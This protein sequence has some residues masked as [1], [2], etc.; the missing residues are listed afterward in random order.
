MS[1]DD[2]FSYLLSLDRI[3]KRSFGERSKGMKI[4]LYRVKEDSLHVHSNDDV[5]SRLGWYHHSWIIDIGFAQQ[6]LTHNRQWMSSSLLPIHSIEALINSDDALSVLTQLYRE[7][8]KEDWSKLLVHGEPVSLPERD[9]ALLS[10]LTNPIKLM[11]AVGLTNHDVFSPTFIISP[12]S[13]VSHVKKAFPGIAFMLGS[14]ANPFIGCCLIS[15]WLKEDQWI[16]SLGPHL[17]ISN[18]WAFLEDQWLIVRYN[19]DILV[20]KKIHLDQLFSTIMDHP[21]WKDSF[22]FGDMISIVFDSMAISVRPGDWVDVQM[23]YLGQLQNRVDK[24]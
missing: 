18:Q 15:C 6:W 19:G 11:G 17:Y 8:L 12:H 21:V 20:K 4:V 2:I 3:N 5:G 16:S 22:S 13:T 9:V 7:I 23:A 1:H 14:K 24:T 10:P